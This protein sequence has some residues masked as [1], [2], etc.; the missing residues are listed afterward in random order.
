MAILI[1]NLFCYCSGGRTGPDTI[2]M[3]GAFAIMTT[4]KYSNYEWF[5]G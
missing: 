5:I 2:N 1:T 4:N 3:A